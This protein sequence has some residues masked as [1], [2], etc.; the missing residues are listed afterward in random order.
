MAVTV[1]ISARASH[2]IPK[3]L[4]G[5]MFE[6]GPAFYSQS[7]D[8]GLYAELLQNRAFQQVTPG[9]TAALSA[10]Q[11]VNKGNITVIRESAPLSA[12]L[13]NALRFS[14]PAGSSGQVG[15][16]NT[17]FYGIKVTAGTSYKASFYYRFP[18][19][20]SFRGNALVQLQTNT[21]TVLGSTTVTLSGSQTS[22]QKIATTIVPTV[23][24]SSTAN[25]FVISVDGGAASGQTINFS[26]LSLFPPTFKDRP[27]GMRIDIAEALQEMGPSFFRFPGGNNLEGQ[28]VA[29]RWKWNDTLGPLTDRPGRMGDWGY[30]NTDGLG[31]LEYLEWCEDLEME[32]IMGVWAGYA[33]GGTSVPENQLQPYIQEATDQINFVIGGSTT[34]GGGYPTHDLCSREQIFPG[35]KRAAL[36]RTEPF[37]LNYVEIGNEDF[38]AD[39]SYVYRWRQFVGNLSATFPQIRFIA[40]SYTS[41]PVLTPTPLHYDVHVYQTPTWFA[42]NA[43]FY[44]DFERNGT[45][46]F[47]GEYAAISTNPGDIFGTPANGRLTYPTMQSAAGEAAFMTGLERNSDIVFSAAYAPLLNH[48]S[49][50]QWTPNLI[51]FDSGA[52]YRSASYYVQK[53]FSVNRGDEYLPSTL[54]SRTGTLFWSVVRQTST[55]SII[56]KIANTA[57]TSAPLTFNLPFNTVASSGTAQ[58]LTGTAT[59]SN[60]PTAP[61]DI[62]PVTRSVTT[63]K[64]LNY[65]APGYSVSVLTVVAS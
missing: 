6:A 38:F 51:S 9:T 11:A 10:W 3:L 21:G 34:T 58:V 39:V 22:W 4:W 23:T 14:V 1:D 56:I 40:T 44:D 29:T 48:V 18:T 36:G 26:L 64:S 47:E 8:G 15:F 33:L 25:R 16:A 13:P 60:T 65:T 42:Q 45:T 19:T 54:P 24:A 35:R 59:R 46:Y 55:K 52:V 43:F 41:G 61:N 20:T 7:G 30:I 63:G 50:T 31:L 12:A 2:P 17:G 37:L 32:P 27:N 5:Q 49:G 28:T 57:G 53:L 62:V